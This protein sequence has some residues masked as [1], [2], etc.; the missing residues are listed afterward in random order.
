MEETSSNRCG[1][2]GTTI[3]RV[4]GGIRPAKAPSSRSSSPS[5]VLARRT[6]RL[7]PKDRLNSAPLAS[8]AGS[9][10]TSNFR[11][12]ATPTW[13]APREAI[14]VAS[15]SLCAHTAAKD[16]NAGRVRPERRLY[17]CPDR[18]DI[19][20]LASTIGSFRRPHS[21]IRLIQI[22]VS[23][24]TP[25]RGWK[26][27]RN[28]RTA[29]GKSYGRN[30]ARTFAPNACLIVSRPAA[31]MQVTR[32][33]CSG[34]SARSAFTKGTLARTSPT[35]TACTQITGRSGFGPYRPNRS[36]TPFAYPGSRRARHQSLDRI[37]GN[38]S[39]SKRVEPARKIKRKWPMQSRLPSQK[40]G[41][42][43]V[44]D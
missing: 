23:T 41:N 11:F 20:P 18:P 6:T 3:K 28:R 26:W 2:R 32:T 40:V 17:A 33:L 37:S 7:S 5:R 8:I 21:A 44:P 13:C 14:R 39:H 24:N 4:P 1:W 10:A 36:L 25:M 29:N 16:S 9:G 19:L 27:S 22:S 30:A 35:D 15:A 43:A 12:P 34:Y 42:S 38:P 31:V